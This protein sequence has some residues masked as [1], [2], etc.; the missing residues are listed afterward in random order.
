M[1]GPSADPVAARS[2]LRLMKGNEAAVHG[3]LLAGCK[4]FYGYPITPASELAET[5]ARSFGDSN[6][7]RA[8]LH[9]TLR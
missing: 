3:A 1:S 5:A 4:S 9:A 7:N 8:E 6:R 2:R